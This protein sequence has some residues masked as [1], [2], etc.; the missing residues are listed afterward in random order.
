MMVP[1]GAEII[2]WISARRIMSY[3][4][5][6][7]KLVEHFL[8]GVPEKNTERRTGICW[9]NISRTSWRTGASSCCCRNA[10]RTRSPPTV[11][12]TKRLSSG[13]KRARNVPSAC[14]RSPGPWR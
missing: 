4:M 12:E 13:S 5:R 6:V 11:F 14:R 2:D 3:D 10:G 1:S 8:S 9:L 7:Y